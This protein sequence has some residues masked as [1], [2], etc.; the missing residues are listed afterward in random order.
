[1]FTRSTSFPPLPSPAAQALPSPRP[2]GLGEGSRAWGPL[3]GPVAGRRGPDRGDRHQWDVEHEDG[4]H[5]GPGLGDP[6]RHVAGGRGAEG[7]GWEHLR[8][9]PPSQRTRRVHWPL[10]LRACAQRAHERMG[11]LSQGTLP[12]RRAGSLRAAGHSLGRVRRSGVVAGEPRQGLQPQGALL[13]R[14]HALAP[15]ALGS[16]GAGCVHGVGRD[17]DARNG[18]AKGGVGDLSRGSARRVRSR[19]GH[20]VRERGHRAEL[21]RVQAVQRGRAGDRGIGSW[22]TGR[23]C[24][25]GATP[26]KEASRRILRTRCRLSAAQR[27]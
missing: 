8:D 20:G 5:H 14:V 22:A 9:L 16:V 27:F 12:V 1:M 24:A 10:L 2:K 3:G 19:G 6:G 11:C 25:R 18:D 13:D 4:P 23:V 17:R 7:R 15:P 21:F 26:G